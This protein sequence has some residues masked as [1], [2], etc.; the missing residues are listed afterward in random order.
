MSSEQSLFHFHPETVINSYKNQDSEHDYRSA[1]E[2]H[3]KNYQ[4]NLYSYYKEMS[5]KT[6]DKSPYYSTAAIFVYDLL[7]QSADSLPINILTTEIPEELI[8]SH[9]ITANEIFGDTRWKNNSWIMAQIPIRENSIY[10]IDREV[11]QSGLL[12]FSDK[13]RSTSPDLA[14]LTYSTLKSFDSPEEKKS[15]LRGIFDMFN[16]YYSF[17]GAQ[18]LSTNLWM[19]EN[20]PTLSALRERYRKEETGTTTPLQVILGWAENM[21]DEIE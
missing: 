21:L 13:L 11:R 15:F 20:K 16:L 14:A 12:D 3:M 6:G 5:D 10:I 2:L 17:V 7:K 9:E 18:N 19:L 4:P 1:L 8:D